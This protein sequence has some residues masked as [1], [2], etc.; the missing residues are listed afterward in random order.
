MSRP[1][2]SEDET[3]EHAHRLIEATFRVVAATGDAVPSIR[4]ILQEAGLSRQAFYRCFGS[5]DDLM[6]AVLVEGQRIL[7]NYLATRMGRAASPSGQVEAWVSGMMRQAEVARAAERT[8]PFIASASQRTAADEVEG[9]GP[10]RVLC[11]LLE[12]AIVAGVADGS[13]HSDAP[14]GDALIIHDFVQASLNRH[15]LQHVSPAP[16]TT[17]MLVGFALRALG[18][19]VEQAAD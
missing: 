6:A 1:R 13:W 11:G 17:R 18:A 9:P 19:R 3:E 16:E 2:L 10:E 8:R 7:A 15:L 5:K 4:P 14:A 12:D